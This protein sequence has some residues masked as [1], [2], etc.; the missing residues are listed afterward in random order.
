MAW[1]D[2]WFD[3]NYMLLYPHRDRADAQRQ[4]D[5]ILATLNLPPGSPVLDLACGIG[6]HTELLYRAGHDV[7][8]LDLSRTMLTEARRLFPH[9]RFL[10]ADMRRI[11]GTYRLI[12]S[13]FTSF[14]YFDDDQ[15][16]IAVLTAVSASL[17]PQG[18]FWLDFLNPGYLRQHL[19]AESTMYLDDGSAVTVRRSLTS[20]RVKKVIEF[21]DGKTYTESVKLYTSDE[22]DYMCRQQGLEIRHRFGDYTGRK[23]QTDSERMILAAR[24]Q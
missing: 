5:L 3:S 6:R 2:K 19:Q 1:Y 17:Y 13:L 12:M 21:P 14:G 11:E 23:Y 8:G 24:K 16:N 20:D 18:W 15:D 10:R 22:I 9:I 7:T 4:V